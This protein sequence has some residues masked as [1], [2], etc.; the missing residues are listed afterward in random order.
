MSTTDYEPQPLPPYAVESVDNALRALLLIRER[1]G[2]RVAECSDA[3]GIARST[4]HRLLMTMAHR[5]FVE[6]ERNT[7]VYRA[8][9]ALMEF[10]FS[11]DD[12]RRLRHFA[13]PVLAQL[14]HDTRETANLLRLEPDGVR[15]IDS[16]EPDRPVRV[17]GRTGVLLPAHATAGGK[18]LL[19]MLPDGGPHPALSGPLRA[20]TSATIT[21]MPDLQDELEEIRRH[22]YAIN[23]GESLDELRAI[24]VRVVKPSGRTIAAL[25]LSVPAD[26]GTVSRLRAFAPVLQS[27]AEGLGRML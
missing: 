21:R 4:A 13:R 17:Q 2:V 27:A 3:L 1:G 5:G 15:F 16:L 19:A 18:M 24:A 22:G 23:R 20:I 11:S 8:G 6:Q 9:P 7:R 26:R 12:V 25:A 14:V 10:V